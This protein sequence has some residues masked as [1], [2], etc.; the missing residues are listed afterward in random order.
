MKKIIALVDCNN[1]FVSCERLFAPWA[2]NKPAVVFSHNEGCIIARSNEAKRIGIGMGEPVFQCREI[3]DFFG[4]CGFSTNFALYSDISS[5][6]M[7]VLK[8]FSPSV[9]QYSVDEA[10]LDLTEIQQENW[11][12][13]GIKIKESILKNLGI[14]VSVGIASSKTL[15][16]IASKFAKKR[17][18]VYVLLNNISEKISD[19]TLIDV[20]GIGYASSKALKNTGVYTVSDLLN[21]PSSWV[22]K[23]YGVN[24]LKT[25]WDL[26]GESAI[27][28]SKPKAFAKSIMHTRTFKNAVV[29]KEEL[30]K[31]VIRY[32]LEIA[33]SLRKQNLKAAGIAI[34]VAENRHSS[35]YFKSYK[36][37]MFLYST[38]LDKEFAKLAGALLDDIFVYGKKY[39]R[40]GVIVSKIVTPDYFNNQLFV[41]SDR[42]ENA[43]MGIDFANEKFKGKVN[44][45]S[46]E[47]IQRE[48]GM[49]TSLEYT[50]NW[51]QLYLVS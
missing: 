28:I 31:K 23:H 34:F 15:A 10:F 25:W 35:G 21:K 51:N 32:A 37:S 9:E 38:N 3:M 16:K 50:T 17:D 36:E 46:S 27:G 24:M 33:K 26:K 42:D 40:A 47:H 48:S 43:Q 2:L 22:L 11:Y 12:Q 44:I 7:R 6:I 1:F 20:W 30:R 8:R 45:A 41:E 13:Y 19:M 49:H 39:K 18:G 4:V 29:Q 5:R 14:P